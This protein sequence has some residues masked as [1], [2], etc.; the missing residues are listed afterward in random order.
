[1]SKTWK[2][3]RKKKAKKEE[4]PL[5]DPGTGMRLEYQIKQE[6]ED[7]QHAYRHIRQWSIFGDDLPRCVMLQITVLSNR[8][9][10]ADAGALANPDEGHRVGIY[11]DCATQAHNWMVGK[12]KTPP[13]WNWRAALNATPQRS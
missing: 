10:L 8:L 12:S 4:A 2:E 9:S 13:S 11:H 3:P 6:L 7:L 1:M 5:L